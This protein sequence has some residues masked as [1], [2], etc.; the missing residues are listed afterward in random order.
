MKNY[1]DR[2]GCVENRLRYWWQYTIVSM[3]HCLHLSNFFSASWL[4]RIRWGI[5]PIR[6]GDLI[7]M[8]II[9]IIIIIIMIVILLSSNYYL[10]PSEVMFTFRSITPVEYPGATL[11]PNS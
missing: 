2:K 10:K 1:A 4:R 11:M 6:N 9:I 8:I 5:K 3:V 7:I